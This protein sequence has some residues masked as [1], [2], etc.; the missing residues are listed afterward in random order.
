MYDIMEKVYNKL[1]VLVVCVL[2]SVLVTALEQRG[3]K[4]NIAKSFLHYNVD[5]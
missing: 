2:A 3:K 1:A 4:Y 5:I